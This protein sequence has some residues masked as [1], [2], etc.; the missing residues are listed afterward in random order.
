VEYFVNL[1]LK[2]FVVRLCVRFFIAHFSIIMVCPSNVFIFTTNRD[3]LVIGNNQ[4]WWG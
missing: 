4:G 2:I 3:S 1:Q